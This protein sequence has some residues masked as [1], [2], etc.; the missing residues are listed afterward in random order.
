MAETSSVGGK[1]HLSRASKPSRGGGGGGG[2]DEVIDPEE[3]RRANLAIDRLSSVG[4]NALPV[5]L[6]PY[7]ALSNGQRAR[8]DVA[9]SLASGV[10]IDDF[11]STVDRA[12]AAVCAAGIAKLVSPTKGLD[13]ERVVIASVH[14]SIAA[15]TGAD[16]AFFPSGV[17]GNGGGGSLLLNPAPGGKPEVS[18]TYDA[19]TTDLEHSRTDA[20]RAELAAGRPPPA[21][22]PP[23]SEK[24]LPSTLWAKKG[25][26]LR[27]EVEPDA[28]TA[29]A[30]AAFEV[31]ASRRSSGA[32]APRSARGAS[33]CS[34][35]RWLRQVDSAPAASARARRCDGLEGARRRGRPAEAGTWPDDA[36][37]AATAVRRRL[38]AFGGEP[39]AAAAPPALRVALAWPAHGG[40]GGAAVPCG[41]G[42]RAREAARERRRVHLVPRSQR[43]DDGG[44]S[45]RRRVA[46]A[47]RRRPPRVRDRPRRRGAH[48]PPRL[49]VQCRDARAD[50][51]HVATHGG[52]RR[53]PPVLAPSPAS[54][55][56][57]STMRRGARRCSRRR[58]CASSFARL[59]SS[60]ATSNG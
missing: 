46:A 58:R 47:L 18:V 11:G 34:S 26:T 36:P 38:A 59:T 16:W 31:A 24:N 55:Q 20:H 39:L 45:E 22:A 33:A 21:G 54:R 32:D 57:P 60:G 9:M 14:D 43:G 28:A 1:S 48:A 42:D 4:L 2:D 56:R 50:A 25:R 37:A 53:A 17:D 49:V 23:L 5:W 35:A 7:S 41:G 27:S 29:A 10:A 12:N 51:V 40:R 8:A 30:S 13:L 15:W 3:K 52:R 44:Q 19:T 6:K